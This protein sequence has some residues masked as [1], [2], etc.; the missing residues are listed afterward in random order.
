MKY[1]NIINGLLIPHYMKNG[2]HYGSSIYNTNGELVMEQRNND[3]CGIKVYNKKNIDLKNFKTN[4]SEESIIYMG[5]LTNH[6]GHFLLETLCRFWI[7]LNKYYDNKL[8]SNTKYV[9]TEFVMGNSSGL[10]NILLKYILNNLNIDP[11]KFILIKKPTIFKKIFLVEKS[12]YL[13]ESID[14]KHKELCN[15]L[16]ENIINKPFYLSKKINFNKRTYIA[17]NIDI[18]KYI[19]PIFKKFDFNII[20]PTINDF[21]QNIIEYHLSSIIAGFEG[22]NTHNI[23]FTRPNTILIIF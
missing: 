13:N 3:R 9:F 15:S 17:R 2:E 22:T 18:E 14:I 16:I 23:L 4:K 20:Y 6:Y 7:F 11:N 10:D 5:Q 21:E 8:H 19:I 12:C 1:I